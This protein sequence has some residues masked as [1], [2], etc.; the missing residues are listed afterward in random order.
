M[1]KTMV[2]TLLAATSF[3][4]VTV[5]QAHA[6]TASYTTTFK[7]VDA[8]TNKTLKTVKTTGSKNK[9]YT[10][11]PVAIKYY[12]T[13]AK[14]SYKV[15]KTSTITLK[16]KAAYRKATI[17]YVDRYNNAT[18]KTATTKMVPVGK[19]A[20]FTPVSVSGYQV[21]STA[22][23]KLA[24]VK[25]DSTVT[26]TYDKLFKLTQN[27][28]AMD[29][30]KS[31][32]TSSQTVKR[33]QTVTL[34]PKSVADYV[35]PPVQKVQVNKDTTATFNYQRLYNVTINSV[36]SD[37][38]KLGS[39]KQTVQQGQTVTAM[40]KNYA[41]YAT[42]ISQKVAPNKDMTVT[43]TY[44]KFYTVNVVEKAADGTVLTTRSM[45]G[46]A[47]QSVKLTPESHEGYVAPKDQTVDQATTVTF[48]YQIDRTHQDDAY[49][50]LIASMDNQDQSKLALATYKA[51][52]TQAT[53]LATYQ[54]A[55]QVMSTM[56]LKSLGG[57]A[58]RIVDSYNS[59]DIIAGKNMGASDITMADGSNDVYI[60]YFASGDYDWV[61]DQTTKQAGWIKQSLLTTDG[62]G[63]R[64]GDAYTYKVEKKS[65]LT[66]SYVYV[67]NDVTGT[68]DSYTIQYGINGNYDDAVVKFTFNKDVNVPVKAGDF[69]MEKASLFV[70]DSDNPIMADSQAT[71]WTNQQVYSV[72]FSIS[73]DDADE[74]IEDGGYVGYG[75]VSDLGEKP[76]AFNLPGENSGDYS[77]SV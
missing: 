69:T 59:N 7:Y 20:S 61:V 65:D 39:V 3:G 38:V 4:L 41:G 46:Q 18:I 31:L 19:T 58:M 40:P 24:N 63:M 57:Q 52:Y 33:G 30:K 48:I 74:L 2:L 29:T 75:S 1:R 43:L 76:H 49:N 15:T 68:L 35:T 6:A 22:T 21:T 8:T 66:G 71:D 64:D 53:T 54:A 14:L 67:G 47:G 23:K 26:F 60:A 10:Y 73:A 51:D 5:G 28:V 45:Q 36:G 50:K 70:G 72:T 32:G 77:T 27:M 37:G 13:P 55:Q 9:T 62:V 34:T 17:K 44:P 56:A 25:L 42:P 11:K 16:V 12:A